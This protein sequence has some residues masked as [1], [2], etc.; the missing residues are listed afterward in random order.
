MTTTDVIYAKPFMTDDGCDHTALILWRMN[1]NARART[2]SL[3]VPVPLPVQ[4]VP[5][6]FSLSQKGAKTRTSKKAKSPLVK[7]TRHEKTISEF[8]LDHV[9]GHYYTC[10]DVTQHGIYGE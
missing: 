4:V 8:T 3:Y 9:D 2:G 6:K 5:S 7:N 10:S 1:A